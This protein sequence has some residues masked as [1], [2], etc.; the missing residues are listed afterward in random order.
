MKTLGCMLFEQI[1]LLPSCT[2]RLSFIGYNVSQAI[3]G[4]T[5]IQRLFQVLICLNCS[6]FLMNS[7]LSEIHFLVIKTA[8]FDFSN[9]IFSPLNGF[10]CGSCEQKQVEHTV[11]AFEKF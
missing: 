11:F 5:D 4:P 6:Y 9:L 10:R 8:V 1:N 2:V 3:H 7:L